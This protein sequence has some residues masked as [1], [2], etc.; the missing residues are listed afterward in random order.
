M[1]KAPYQ[2]GAFLF[3]QDSEI[4]LRLFFIIVVLSLSG[5][6]SNETE[7]AVN[8]K[9]VDQHINRAAQALPPQ[10]NTEKRT[11]TVKPQSKRKSLYITQKKQ[12]QSN[13]KRLQQPSLFYE[14]YEGFDPE[15]EDDWE[16]LNYLGELKNS[17]DPKVRVE[18]IEA[19]DD[20]EAYRILKPLR[21]AL[22]DTEQGVRIAALKK[23]SEIELYGAVDSIL[24]ALDDPDSDVV[25]AAIDAVEATADE[26]LIPKLVPLLQHPNNKIQ[27]RAEEVIEYMN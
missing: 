5:C 9:A 26:S 23:L 24:Y 13:R 21:N 20:I 22:D 15:D 18:A 16:Q 1:T 11:Q 10:N 14:D 27:Q 3:L 25:M 12:V 17:T 7:N 2:K 6:N 8:N 4:V 19:L